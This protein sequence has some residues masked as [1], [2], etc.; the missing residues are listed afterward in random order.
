MRNGRRIEGGRRP[1]GF[2]SP[3]VNFN[4]PPITAGLEFFG[5]LS[6]PN[7]SVVSGAVA[8][9]GDAS[10]YGRHRTQSTGSARPTFT[11]TDATFGSRP[12]MTYDAIGDFLGGSAFAAS[13]GNT[14]TFY[15]V[16]RWGIT[17]GNQN[18]IGFGTPANTARVFCS[19][20]GVSLQGQFNNP[21][22]VETRR[23][24]A[25]TPAT[26]YR[27]CGVFDATVGATA[28]RFLYLNGADTSALVSVLASNGGPF[29][30]QILYIGGNVGGTGLLSGTITDTLLYSGAHSAAQVAAMDGWLKLRNGL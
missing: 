27:V 21:D 30:S 14:C 12:S 18:I 9:L 7:T 4:L 6:S 13:S 8:Q 29:A 16:V 24:V 11:A 1:G 15:A 19:S 20:T 28:A 26:P 23:S 17:A 10:G 22:N 5:D 25:T 3:S 2:V